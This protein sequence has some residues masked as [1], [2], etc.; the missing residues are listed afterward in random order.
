MFTSTFSTLASMVV[1]A[2]AVA[3]SPVARA[4]AITD[5]QVLNFALTLEHLE[6]AFYKEGLAN[7]SDA[8]FQNAGFPSWVRNR[9]TEIAAHEASHVAFLSSALGS[10]A[11][12]PC[13]YSFGVTDVKSFI[14]TSYALEGVGTAAYTG[15]AALISTKAY[16]TAAATI[17]TV[18]ARHDAWVGS[19][20]KQGAAWSTAYETPLDPNQVYT[21]ASA[22]ITS[23]PSSNP[24][25][26]VT[27]FPALTVS[28]EGSRAP[29]STVTFAS[30]ALSDGS[31]L[32]AGFLNGQTATVV[33]LNS[34][35]TVTVPDG[36]LG[37]VYVIITN[38]SSEV[39]DANT[40][41]GPAI[42]D[43]GFNSEEMFVD[44]KF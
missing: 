30:K 12:Q 34:D 13:T 14:D 5:T 32:F 37:T 31:N 33:P 44:S 25:L 8:D 11:T 15:A 7:Y 28:D 21:L 36:L 18:E 20:V 43:L 9:F 17:L 6:N 39:T 2:T 35:M 16:L 22:F 1:L 42:L 26:P 4:D 40:V 24:P 29:G 10:S 19:A 38:S 23:C 41:A 3:A 27:G